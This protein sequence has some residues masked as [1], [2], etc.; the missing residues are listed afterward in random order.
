MPVGRIRRALVVGGG[1]GGLTAA[2]ILAWRGVE[3]VLVE[4]R[5]AFDIPG[6]GLGQP[7]NALRVYDTLGV[8]DEILATGFNYDRMFLFD[9]D[10]RLIV[11]H[12][13]L[14]GD[15]RIPAFCALS[16]LQLH[17]ILLGAVERAGVNVRLGATAT[18]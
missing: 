4:R 1:V 9:R 10:R 18:E 13:F 5:P 12:K 3:V 17:E 8:L 11:E 6:V 14:L 2:A 15:D 7:A 16:R